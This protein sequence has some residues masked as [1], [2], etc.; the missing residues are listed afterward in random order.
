VLRLLPFYDDR[1]DDEVGVV[2]VDGGDD[3]RQEDAVVG[4]RVFDDVPHVILGAVSVE[5]ARLHITRLDDL[6]AEIDQHVAVDVDRVGDPA[7]DAW[8]EPDAVV[9]PLIEAPGDVAE[10]DR[11]ILRIVGMRAHCQFAAVGELVA[12]GRIEHRNKSDREVDRVP[13]DSANS[14]LVD[15]CVG[16]VVQWIRRVAWEALARVEGEGLTQITL[17][18]VGESIV[19]GVGVTG[20]GLVG[21]RLRRAVECKSG[22]IGLVHTQSELRDSR[23]V[24]SHPHRTEIRPNTQGD[25]A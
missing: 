24:E 7:A 9:D 6:Q 19:I 3:A 12:V 13:I 8:F 4:E 17:V 18:M 25:E 21:V 10:G 14:I 5:I 11:M 1:V 2:V 16:V 23:G 15:R 22:P 20:I